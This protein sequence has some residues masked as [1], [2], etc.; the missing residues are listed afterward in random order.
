MESNSTR[1]VLLGFA[2]AQFVSSLDTMAYGLAKWRYFGQPIRRVTQHSIISDGEFRPYPTM[3]FYLPNWTRPISLAVLLV[4]GII[5]WAFLCHSQLYSLPESLVVQFGD[6]ENFLIGFASGNYTRTRRT[7][8]IM[9]RHTDLVY[10]LDDLE[11]DGNPF[12][13]KYC[14]KDS[15]WRLL[16]SEFDNCNNDKWLVRSSKIKGASFRIPSSEDHGW[17]AKSGVEPDAIICQ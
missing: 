17:F 7:N 11:L 2:A 9:A 8:S 5:S 16:M 14:M 4:I 13:L 3:N 15:T 10:M 1:D 6:D 12:T